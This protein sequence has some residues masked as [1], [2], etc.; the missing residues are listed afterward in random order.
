M[1]DRQK[2]KANLQPQELISVL[3]DLSKLI[4]EAIKSQ[5]LDF[6]DPILANND[7]LAPMEWNVAEVDTMLN[8]MFSFLRS[9]YN[10]EA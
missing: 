8:E 1:N 9:S 2:S 7:Y 3:D 10:R 6:H 4:E 5:R